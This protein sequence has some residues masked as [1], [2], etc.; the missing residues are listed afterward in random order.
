MLRLWLS[1][2]ILTALANRDRDLTATVAQLQELYRRLR[3]IEVRLQQRYA[4]GTDEHGLGVTT[5][6]AQGLDRALLERKGFR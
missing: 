1:G 2:P 3:L 4:R 6:E 5:R